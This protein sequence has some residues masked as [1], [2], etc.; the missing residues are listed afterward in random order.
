MT[1]QNSGKILVCKEQKNKACWLG[2]KRLMGPS[3]TYVLNPTSAAT[4]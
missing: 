4:R 2:L 1:M 3:L